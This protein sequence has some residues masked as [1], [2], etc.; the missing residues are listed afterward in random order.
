MKVRKRYKQIISKLKSVPERRSFF[1]SVLTFT[2]PVVSRFKSFFCFLAPIFLLGS[3]HTEKLFKSKNPYETYSDALKNTGLEEYKII[4]KW[5][6]NGQVSAVVNLDAQNLPHAEMVYFDPAM[7]EAEFW[8]YE[9]EEGSQ[10]SINANALSDSGT[11]YFLEVFRNTI[12]GYSSLVFSQDR[13]TIAY[14]AQENENHLLRIQPEL[15]G[16]GMIEVNIKVSG[17]IVFPISNMNAGQIASFWGDARG[18]SRR[19]EGVDVFASRGTP[20]RAVVDGRVNRSDQNRLGGKVV[21]LNNDKYNFYY[22]HLDSQMVHIGQR[23]KMGDTLGMVGNTGNARTTAPHLHFGIYRRG[24]GAKNPLPFLQTPK[25]IDKIS[26]SD[27]VSLKDYGVF[28]AKAGNLRASPTLNAKIIGTY[29]K[30][31][32][33]DIMGKS[34]VWFRIRLPDHTIGFAHQTI[35]NISEKSSPE[36]ELKAV[37][38]VFQDWKKSWPISS[39]YFIGKGNILGYFKDMVYVRLKTGSKIWMQVK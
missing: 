35:L 1:P 8:L 31:T 30:N 17:S 34:G 19:H 27:T 10:V 36:I 33:F 18:S 32:Y 6:S 3:C 11:V 12:S 39:D 25:K 37:D 4:K 2:N 23:V 24:S 38:L 16:G 14:T 9:V 15:L 5:I 7:A 28:S 26:A 13:Q 20:V 29:S 22:A 21:W